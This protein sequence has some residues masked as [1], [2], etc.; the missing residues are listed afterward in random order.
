MSGQ[1]WQARRHRILL[2]G[3]FPG[4][5]GLPRLAVCLAH[6]IPADAPL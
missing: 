4:G 5:R 2:T 3:R 1:A 6:V